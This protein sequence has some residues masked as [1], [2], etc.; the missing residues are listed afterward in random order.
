MEC[1]ILVCC[2]RVFL[3][4][5]PWKIFS[6]DF[7]FMELLLHFDGRLFIFVYF[8][9]PSMNCAVTFEIDMIYV[10]FSFYLSI[11]NFRQREIHSIFAEKPFPKITSDFISERKQIPLNCIL[12]GGIEENER[13]VVFVSILSGYWLSKEF[14]DFPRFRLHKNTNKH[15]FQMFYLLFSCINRILSFFRLI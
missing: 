15:A 1:V 13:K 12:S 6:S 4:P 8:I 7:D 3:I 10:A 9:F 14:S 5:L 2:L 11:F